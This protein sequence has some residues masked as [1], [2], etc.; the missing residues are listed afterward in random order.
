MTLH[1]DEDNQGSNDG[2]VTVIVTRKAKKGK[3]SEFEEWMDG[4]I[5]EAMKFEGHMGVNVMRPPDLSNPEYVIIFRFNTYKNLARWEKSEIREEWLKKSK[6]VTEG[7]P[8]VQKQTGLEFWFTPLRGNEQVT[9]PPRYK[10]A[11]V[12]GGVVF[13]LLST[14]VPQIRQ[15]TATLPVLL[16]TLVGVAIMVLL[17]TYVIMPTVTKLLRPWL[18]KKKLF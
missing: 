12:T 17:M 7:D 9:P 11:M 1:H 5:H 4:I 13:V 8:V 10:M 2:P 3:I 18:A 16:S 14:L 6:D 15:M